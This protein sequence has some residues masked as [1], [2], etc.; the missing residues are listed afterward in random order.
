MIRNFIIWS[1]CKQLWKTLIKKDSLNKK[2]YT[3]K[4]VKENSLGQHRKIYLFSLDSKK[5]QIKNLAWHLFFQF[6]NCVWGWGVGG[7]G[8]CAHVHEHMKKALHLLQLEL[9]AVVSHGTQVPE[10][11]LQSSKR[12]QK[13]VLPADPHLLPHHLSFAGRED[14]NVLFVHCLETWG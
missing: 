7:S 6:V 1:T 14:L 11:E 10:T 12:A 4:E 13:C 3:Q 8:L 5:I 2:N 9:H